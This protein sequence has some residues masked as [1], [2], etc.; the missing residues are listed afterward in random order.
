MTRPVPS[1]VREIYEGFR[2]GGGAEV[3]Q[4]RGWIGAVVFGGA[5]GLRDPEAVV[6]D[7]LVRLYQLACA[8][9]IDD[10]QAFQKYVY[11]VAKNDCLTAL[12]RQRRLTEHEVATTD[13]DAPCVPPTDPGEMT[14]AER[15]SAIRYV[16][17]RLP[18]ECRRLWLLIYREKLT[19]RQIA[20]R[21]GTKAGTVRVR[22]HRCLEK[23]RAI[24]RA[25]SG[26][27]PAVGEG[28]S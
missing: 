1:E 4:V 9:R 19:S 16:L 12:R 15:E 8:G 18:G 6:Q 23:A 3:K 24:Y 17:Q 25:Y 7:V 14:S 13:R 20:E 10:P 11:T 21:L 26:W 22:A 27:S 2:R 5:W 28:E